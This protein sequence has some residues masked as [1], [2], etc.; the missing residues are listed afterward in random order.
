[1]I[2]YRV[3]GVTVLHSILIAAAAAGL[4][5]FWIGVHFSFRLAG[6]PVTHSRYAAYMGVIMAA[7]GLDLVISKLHNT[8][9]LELDLIGVLKLSLR[10]VLTVLGVLLLFLVAQKDTAIS[11][12]FLFSFLPILFGGLVALNRTVP[13]LI[14]SRLFHSERRERTLLVGSPAQ[15]QRMLAWLKGKSRYGVD[16]LGLVTDQKPTG[17]PAPWPTI[18]GTE[19]LPQLVQTTGAR[20]VILLEMPDALSRAAEIGGQCEQLGVRLLIVN[21][22][23][24][25]LTE[26]FQRPVFFFEDGGVRFI[27]LREEPLECP[28]N[29]IL[30]RTLDI[31]V[32]LP[33]V[34]LIIPPLSMLV[35]LVHRLQSPG[36]LFFRQCR[37]GIRFD[38]FWI[39]KFRTMD[40]ANP[41]EKAQATA[42]DPR[43]FAFGRWLRRLSIDELPQFINVLRGEMS[44]VGPRPHMV[45]HDAEFEKLAETYRVRSFVKPGITGLA[46]VEGLRGEARRREDVVDRVRCDVYY[47]ENWSLGM[48]WRIIVRTAWQMLRPPKTAY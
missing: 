19:E 14:A 2:T 15:A 25:S 33:V 35:W 32:S 47:L 7:L 12:I 9:L 39:F 5:W 17:D 44:V 34:V 29:R 38:P 8:D 40:V 43:V 21:D 48:D 23:E 27:S 16:I 22:I 10:Q 37:T 1:M 3:R 6:T 24:K 28:F 11:R 45:E 13:R 31:A 20:Q 26:T 46:Q 42:E 18:G 30:K 41:D 4:F 36:P